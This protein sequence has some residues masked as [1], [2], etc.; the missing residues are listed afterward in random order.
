MTNDWRLMGQQT[1]LAGRDLQWHQWSPYRPGWDHDHCAFC[2][3]EIAA[4]ADHPAFTAGYVTADDRYTWICPPCY[5]DF[6]EQ[7]QWHVLPTST[8]S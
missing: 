3:V 2:H 6:H 5:D 8:D 4:T 1:W 7:F